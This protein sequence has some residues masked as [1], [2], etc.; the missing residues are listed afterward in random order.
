MY[1]CFVCK[2][3][4]ERVHMNVE[5]AMQYMYMC[6]TL[7][8]SSLLQHAVSRAILMDEHVRFIL[9]VYFETSKKM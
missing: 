2:D 5:L 6:L 4:I 3:F 8:L 1:H 9:Q 7:N